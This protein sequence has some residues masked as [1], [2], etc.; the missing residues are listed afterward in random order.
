MKSEQVWLPT[1]CS[2]GAGEEQEGDKFY[3]RLINLHEA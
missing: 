2:E 3:S 1:P